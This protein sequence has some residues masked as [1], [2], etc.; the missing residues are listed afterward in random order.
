MFEKSPWGWGG[1]GDFGMYSNCI[2]LV[3]A[4]VCH[5][6]VYFFFFLGMSMILD[7]RAK[8]N[9]YLAGKHL[10]LE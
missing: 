6:S 5:M 1:G 10:N 4:S 7:G 9:S 8:L 2:P 3:M